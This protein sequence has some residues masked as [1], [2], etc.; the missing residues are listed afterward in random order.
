M[1]VGLWPKS[2]IGKE[3]VSV[4]VGHQ[5]E[6]ASLNLKVGFPIAAVPSEEGLGNLRHI[7]VNH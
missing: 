7:Q 2:L 5:A 3:L 6:V 1:C 4:R